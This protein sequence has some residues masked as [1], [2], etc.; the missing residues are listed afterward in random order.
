MFRKRLKKRTHASTVAPVFLTVIEV[1]VETPSALR[2]V[3][4]PHASITY[5]RGQFVTLLV[6]IG[7][8]IYRRAYSLCTSPGTEQPPAIIIKRVAGGIVSN[9]LNDT[10]K[11]GQQ[12]QVLPPMGYFVTDYDASRKRLYFFVAGGS[13]ITPLFSLVQTILRKEPDAVLHMLYGNRTV[14]DIILAKSLQHLQDTYAPR[15]QVQHVLEQPPAGDTSV[16]HGQVDEQVQRTFFSRYTDEERKQ[17]IYFLCGPAPMRATAEA[18]L[19]T[20]GVAPSV[21]HKESFVA[22]E[23]CP[24]TLLTTQ[25]QHVILRLAGEELNLQVPAGETLLEAGIAADHD[26]PYSCEKGVCTSCKGRLLQG[27]I[28]HI[29]PPEVL[30]EEEIAEG[31]IL[32]CMAQ[33]ISANVIVE[34][35]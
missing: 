2:V 20:Y 23:T 29:R 13:G 25:V 9:F 24:D 30:S 14:A 21:I 4:S 35:D 17:A 19:A 8:K 6:Q 28:Q 33:P 16:L 31:Y 5:Q 34:I 32:C 15:L 18:V 7:D 26:M 1:H 3:F 10:L 11:V 27:Q 12:L 22:G